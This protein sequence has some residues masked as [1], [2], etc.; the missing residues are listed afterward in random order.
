MKRIVLSICIATAA[1]GVGACERHSAENLPEHY[2][3]K[4][5]TE[6]SQAPAHGEQ[7]KSPAGTHKG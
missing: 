5:Q 6:H 7:E 2:R 3:H 4:G 1:L